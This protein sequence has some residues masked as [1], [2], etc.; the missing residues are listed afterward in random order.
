MKIISM[1]Y[2][3]GYLYPWEAHSFMVLHVLEIVEKELIGGHMDGGENPTV[4]FTD[5]VC[6]ELKESKWSSSF[7][8]TASEISRAL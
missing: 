2:L 7:R 6:I 8:Q 3:G 4:R 1:I 5:C